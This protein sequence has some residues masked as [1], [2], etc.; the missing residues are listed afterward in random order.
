MSLNIDQEVDTTQSVFYNFNNLPLTNILLNNTEAT[1][2][3][4]TAPNNTFIQADVTETS[5]SNLTYTQ[6]TVSSEYRSTAIYIIGSSDG[7]MVPQITGIQ[8][9]QQGQLIIINT[10]VS[11]SST[12]PETIKM[13]F[14]LIVT[15]VAAEQN[16]LDL[17]FRSAQPM[18][19]TD[20]SGNKQT[21][22]NGGSA[23]INIQKTLDEQIKADTKYFIF[24]DGDNGKVVIFG[25]I[26]YIISVSMYTL[27][28]PY[29]ADD[30]L[31]PAAYT[32]TDTTAYNTIL[33]T[34]PGQW[35]ECDYVDVDSDNV[36]VTL[37]SGK[38]QDDAAYNSL[39]TMM[40][41]ILFIIFTAFSYTLIPQ[42]YILMLKAFF[43]FM[44]AE[45]KGKQ[46]RAMES[47]DLGAL[48]FFFVLCFLF[49]AIGINQ[50]P[51]LLLYGVCLGILTM[52]GHIIIKSKKSMA[53]AEEWPITEIQLS[54]MRD[55]K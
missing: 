44:E 23:T 47:F 6:G 5:S 1:V 27:R 15:S 28:T 9:P 34:Q 49:I 46:S 33:A 8:S 2:S 19:I 4:S 7:S 3:D 54:N 16:D 12:N 31:F 30:S 17:V 14:P 43:A 45:T 55:S 37:S 24:D 52:L 53:S 29:Y 40:M 18:S 25:G 20:A 35:M 36:A 48:I 50:S 41:Y 38:V 32:F 21:N 22:T 39:R 42:I 13:I 51:L 26:Y 10:L 11:Q